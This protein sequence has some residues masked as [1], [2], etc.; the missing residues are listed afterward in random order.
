MAKFKATLFLF[1]LSLLLGGC[2]QLLRHPNPPVS[3]RGVLDLR[4]WDFERHGRITL[5]GEWRFYWKDFVI[6]DELDVV[7]RG[8]KARFVT[9]PS[10]WNHYQFEEGHLPSHGYATY[11]LKI[12]LN[13]NHPRLSLKL[14]SFGTAYELYVNR[15]LIASNGSIGKHQFEMIPF[16]LPMVHVFENNS[17]YLELFIQVSNFYHKDGGFW[18]SIYL[19]TEP[20]ISNLKDRLVAIDLLITGS[21]LIMAFYHFG[22]FLLRR[23]DL[24]ALYFC[25]V[26]ILIAIQTLISDE[27]YLLRL[28]PDLRWEFTFRVE[29]VS[30]YLG[31]CF[32]VLFAQSVYPVEFS[33]QVRKIVQLIFLIFAVLALILPPTA[34]FQVHVLGQLIMFAVGIY[35][36]YTLVRAIIQSREGARVFLFGF[37]IFFAAVTNEFLHETKLLDTRSFLNYG[38]LTFVFFQSFVLSVRYAKAFSKVEEFT[39]T[40]EKRVQERTAEISKQNLELEIQ[41]SEIIRKNEIIERKN[42]NIT[43]SINYASRIQKAILGSEDSISSNFKDSFIFLKPRDIVSGDF[44]W[45]T[46][47]KKSGITKNLDRQTVFYK[48]IVAADCTGHGIPGS[49][50]T[51]LGNTLLDEIINENKL[52]NVSRVLSVLDRKLLMKLEPHGVNDGMDMA[53]LIFDQ[54]NNQVSFA[55]AQSPLI[56]IREGKV[57]QYKGSKFPIGSSQY[58]VKKKFESHTIDC[59]PGDCYYIF[60]DGFQDQFG[61]L[62]DKKYLKKRFREFLLSI[63]HLPMEDQ[64]RLLH[65][66]LKAWQGEQAQTDDILVVGIRT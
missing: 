56:L 52:T 20:Q 9:V 11:H 28:F 39:S 23:K 29:Y 14:P 40:L 27:K 37:I 51:V 4:N 18:D 59:K 66:E 53:I 38:L 26:G 17:D 19:G 35:L 57:Y 63:H 21:L 50:M 49:F 65:E 47:V 12:I 61:G 2:S 16:S 62:E 6:H 32:Y 31:I 45:F 44:Y 60:S 36:L 13:K 1:S 24:S 43:A 64:K 8:E 25:I 46:E 22:I 55:G 58:R 33:K 34:F 7:E 3:Y 54:D 10:P 5:D 30:I 41:K 42:E 15:K 48:V